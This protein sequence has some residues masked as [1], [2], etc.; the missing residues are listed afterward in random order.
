MSGT[1]SV[2]S[3]SLTAQGYQTPA[4]S[5]IVEGALTDINACFGGVL[6]I[7]DNSGNPELRTPQGQLATTEA[8]VIG[9]QNAQMLL[10]LNGVDPAL[11]TG[12]MQD[13]IGRIYF[14]ERFPAT[15]TT[16][17]VFCQGLP[18]TPIPMG[19]P[20]GNDDGN[21]YVSIADGEIDATSS[22]TIQ[23]ACLTTG[24]IA[25]P[26]GTLHKMQRIIPGWDSGANLVDGVVGRDVES[27][28]QFE[29]RRGQ[30]VAAN[31]NGS[32]PSVQGS[33]FQVT[34][35]LDCFVTDNATGSPV[36]ID[37]VTVPP[38]GLYVC[39]AGGAPA[40]IAM[41]I[42]K[43]KMPGCPYAAANTTVTVTDPS[44]SYGGSGPTYPVTWQVA[45]AQTL[46]MTV[47][48][49]NSPAVPSNVLSL[50]QTAVI[51][52]FN[53]GDGAPVARIGQTV[54][55]SRYVCPVAALGNWVQIIKIKL[56]SNTAPDAS[57]TGSITGSALTVSGTVT[58]AIA[59][60]ATLTAPGV[61]DGTKITAGAGTA[62]TIAPGLAAPVASE[63][64]TTVTPSLDDVTV[65]QAHIPV[66]TA[67]NV[68]V[69]LV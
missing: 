57:F 45:T 65:G 5:A 10:I 17:P 36:V 56:G 32:I 59:I 62:W 55:A 12:R 69:V 18:N 41:A 47:T 42:W 34:N 22:T 48:L 49:K 60:G 35:I 30:T 24:P 14:I 43:K 46:V 38:S 7:E 27:P 26:E 66:L 58:G 23:F 6:N 33:V 2:P 3:P 20:L 9:D 1:T 68:S 44:P 4:E 61:P 29:L 39:T 28:A 50:V 53:G 25:C 19:T 63:T 8:A 11:S 54:Y 64:M 21:L 37:G 40:D 67:A 31:S 52:A 51:N 13:G 15:P 16:V